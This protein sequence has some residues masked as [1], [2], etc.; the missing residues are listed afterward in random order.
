METIS[1]QVYTMD[2]SKNPTYHTWNYVL[3]L[4]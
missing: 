4:D 3:F 1:N 2:A